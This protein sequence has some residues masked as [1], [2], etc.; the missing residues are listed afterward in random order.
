MFVYKWLTI[1]STILINVYKTYIHYLGLKKVFYFCGLEATNQQAN[2]TKKQ[3]RQVG[4][5]DNKL[6]QK[7]IIEGVQEDNTT[8]NQLDV[9]RLR[10]PDETKRIIVG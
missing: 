6:E 8:I 7:V 2:D 5:M 10:I 4:T 1:V 3:Y 9:S